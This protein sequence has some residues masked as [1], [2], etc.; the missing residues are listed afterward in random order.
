MEKKLV[1]VMMK[2][3]SAVGGK[4]EDALAGLEAF[5]KAHPKS[6]LLADVKDA[7]GKVKEAIEAQKAEALKLAEPAKTA[8]SKGQ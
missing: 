7:K 6:T 8:P 2:A 1:P 3:Y 4:Y 5:E